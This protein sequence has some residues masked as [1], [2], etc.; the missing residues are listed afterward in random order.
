MAQTPEQRKR[1][2]KFTKEQNAKRGKP[3]Q[4]LKKK[5]EFKS[6]VSPVVLGITLPRLA[7]LNIVLYCIA[8]GERILILGVVFRSSRIC[9]LRWSDIRIA[10]QV[11]PPV[12]E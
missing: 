8:L 4:E 9:C 5:Q 11:L 3:A 1:N 12:R 6:P 2:A 10:Q 7:D